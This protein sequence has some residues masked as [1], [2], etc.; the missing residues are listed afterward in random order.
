M[1]VF[2]GIELPVE[3]RAALDAVLGAVGVP[4]KPTPPE[5]WHI[6]LRYIGSID[7]VSVDRLL[8]G[9]DEADLGA[10]F[11][12]RTRGLGAF[13][14]TV[15]ATVLWLGL[16]PSPLD[17]LA[18][19]VDAVVERI[20]LGSEERPFVGHVTLSRIRP[21]ADVTD[22][23]EG[24]DVPHVPI[25]VDRVTVFESVQGSGHPRYVPIERI[26]L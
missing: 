12:I 13:P 24:V 11:R 10:P 18:G 25:P 17:L 26:G 2:V 21:P 8:A 22:L 3:A 1:R 6:T 14:N 15:R 16:G 20:G 5:N 9:L 7:E 23:V 4:G 19:V